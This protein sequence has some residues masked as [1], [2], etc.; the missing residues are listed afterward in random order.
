MVFPC[1]VTIL[2]IPSE[3]AFLGRPPAAFEI[4][5]DGTSVHLYRVRMA[6]WLPL[7]SSSLP[8][9]PTLG[10]VQAKPENWPMEFPVTSVEMT[11]VVGGTDVAFNATHRRQT[12]RQRSH[13]SN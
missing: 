1:S 5:D 2:D 8:P 13:L 7:S 6:T 12:T 4:Q 9:L 10:S 11:N 3:A